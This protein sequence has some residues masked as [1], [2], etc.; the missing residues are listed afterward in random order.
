MVME[1]FR[2]KMKEQ[3]L[4]K[5]KEV[6]DNSPDPFKWLIGEIIDHN[7][8]SWIYNKLRDETIGQE[9]VLE[10]GFTT[11]QLKWINQVNEQLKGHSLEHKPGKKPPHS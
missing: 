8:E 5:G 1:E 11:N 4:T 2:K 9:T 10:T 3:V 6:M 7:I